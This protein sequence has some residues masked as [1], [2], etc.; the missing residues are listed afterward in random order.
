MNGVDA[1]LPHGGC[2]QAEREELS[3]DNRRAMDRFLAG[4]EVGAFR[5][6]QFAVRD[7]DDALDIVQDTMIRLTR[8]Y[9][10]R[11]EGEWAPLF[12]RILKNRITD[13]QRRST[14][15]NR[16]FAWLGRGREEDTVPDPVAQA[17]GRDSDRPERQLAT[18]DAMQELEAAVQALP[19][20]QQ[21]A[22]LLRALEELSVADTAQAMGCSE[23]SVKTHYSRAVHSL[24]E[25][26][27]DHWE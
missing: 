17:P 27:G 11:P 1:T 21:Q 5:M 12:F 18:S 24:R 13:H 22:F 20:R 14:V 6:A 3:L 8:S 7:A 26:L 9:S 15:R 2:L 10:Q 16:V 19:A 25:V 4:V 23:G